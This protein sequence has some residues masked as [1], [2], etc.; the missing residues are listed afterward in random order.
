MTEFLKSDPTIDKIVTESAAGGFEAM[1]EALLQHLAKSGTIQR[2]TGCTFGVRL[3]Q[4]QTP[5]P[6]Q[7]ASVPAGPV[8]PTCVRVIYPN[9]NDRFQIFGNS[10]NELDA[11]EENIRKMYGQ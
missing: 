9:G 10:E 5:E 3:L 8:A 2:E 1:R 4:P 11:K 6:S 7:D